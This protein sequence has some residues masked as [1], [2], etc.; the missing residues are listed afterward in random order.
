MDGSDLFECSDI[1]RAKCSIGGKVVANVG[2]VQ[3]VH[4][5][6]VASS[7]FSVTIGGETSEGINIGDS[8][9]VVEEKLNAFTKMELGK[10]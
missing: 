8:L 3:E 1:L 7:P 5:I 9:S 2:T 10:F 6:H 4:E